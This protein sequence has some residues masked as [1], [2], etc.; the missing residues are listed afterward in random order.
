MENPTVSGLRSRS[1]SKTPF[2]RSSCDRESCGETGD[3]AHHKTGRKTPT[4]RSTPVKQLNQAASKVAPEPITEEEEHESPPAHR[5]RLSAKASEKLI[6]TSDYSSEESLDRVRGHRKEIIQNE[7]NSQY[8]RVTTSSQQHSRR[9]LADLTLS[10]I[11]HNVTHD[12]SASRSSRFGSPAYSACSTDSSFAEQALAD[13]TA[14]LDRD[15]SLDHLPYKLYKLAGEYWNKYPKTDYTYSP[16][17]K[18]RVE[19]APGQVAVPNMSRRSLSQFRVHGPNTSEEEIRRLAEATSWA[20]K[21]LTTD[22]VDSSD[23]ESYLR[24]NGG[25]IPD[26]RWWITRLLIAIITTVTTVVTTTTSAV[27]NAV[28]GGYRKVVG[29]SHRYPYTERSPPQG[30]AVAGR[31]RKVVGLSHRYPYTERSPPQGNA[32]AGRYRKVVGPSHRYPYTERSPPQASIASRTASAA[33]APFVWMYTIIKKV[34]TTT[35]TTVTETFSPSLVSDRRAQYAASSRVQ[36]KQGRRWWWL[37]LLLPILGYGSYYTYENLDHLAM[38]NFT[39][40][41][42][43]LKEFTA[44]EM[45]T[46]TLPSLPNI[47]LPEMPAL[48]QINITMPDISLPDMSKSM[49]EVRKTYR[50]YSAIVQNRV[51]DASDYMKVV[52]ESCYNCADQILPQKPEIVDTYKSP[53][54]VQDPDLSKRMAALE[55][56]AVNVDTKLKS[57]DQKLSKLDNL[58][59]QIEHYSLKHLQNNLIQIFN[60]NDN[61]DA[62]ALKLKEYFDKHYMTREE[63]QKISLEIHERLI[64]SWKPDLDEDRIRQMIQEY[65]AVFERNQMQLILERVKEY[66]KEIEIRH[67]E[68]GFD[69]EAVKRIVAGMLEVYDA[70]KTGLVDYALESAGGQVVSTR[71]TELYQIKTKQYSILGMPVWWV[72][73]SPRYAL[74]PGA[75]PAECWAFQGFPGY[76]GECC[77]TVPGQDEAVQHPGH[78]GVVGVHVPAL[79]PHAGRHAG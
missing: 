72:Y 56:W 52:A 3:H 57:F 33:A 43:D 53:E 66:V 14:L 39:D 76:L 32:V 23:D 25:Y 16:L 42:I 64:S 9:T 77:G 63:T 71:C 73:T 8:E 54:I 75:M 18:D 12:R 34:V 65:L 50:E 47:S 21:R 20:R 51:G 49:P 17:S 62:I 36:Q 13:A 2:L 5:T 27:G 15:P 30:N 10:P 40:F 11:G 31:Y 7:I 69:V 19:L 79:R 4:K 68:S 37:L 44:I 58:E 74:T 67:V 41:A 70:D 29:P 1:R 6:K 38:P 26:Q 28:A 60:M 48:P 46:I 78:A 22:R 55:H 59:A 45:P 61:S 24:P 35:V